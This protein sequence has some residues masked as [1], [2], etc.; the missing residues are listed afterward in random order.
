MRELQ[1]HQNSKIKEA[2]GLSAS[3]EHKR[4][5]K[6]T[7]KKQY[8]K[9]RVQGQDTI[10]FIKKNQVPRHKKV[11]YV[12]LYC[13]HWQKK[14]D[15]PNR[16]RIMVGSDRIEYKRE[17]STKVSNMGTSEIIIKSTI[18]TKGANFACW[19]V[20]NFYTNLS[21]EEPESMRIYIQEKLNKVI[22]KYNV[23]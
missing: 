2:Q 23:I 4:L 6:G 8:F 20:G 11:T 5:L 17:T 16:M 9:S 19:D 22:E 10:H 3:N 21:L 7:G 15:E 18:S 14:T 12:R 13:N 1:T